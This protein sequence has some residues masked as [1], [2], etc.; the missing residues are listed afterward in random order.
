MSV[1]RK[2][3]N[4]DL[5]TNILKQIYNN[6]DYINAYKEIRDFM[7]KNGFEHRQGS[8]YVSKDR[9]RETDAIL[10]YN[11]MVTTF[12]WFNQAVKKCDLT[13]IGRT[14]DLTGKINNNGKARF[15]SKV[16]DLT[17]DNALSDCQTIYDDYEDEYSRGR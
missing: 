4:F 6:G 15:D 8:G 11:N 14:L 10:I 12:P 2:A 13:H 9:M 17:L 5:D 1:S 7:E 16:S 3:I